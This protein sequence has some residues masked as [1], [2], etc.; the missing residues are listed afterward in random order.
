MALLANTNF[1]QLLVDMTSDSK[2]ESVRVCIK[3][4]CLQAYFK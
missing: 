2:V 3:V 4:M 1:M